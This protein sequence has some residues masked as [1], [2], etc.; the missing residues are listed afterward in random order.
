M[1][2]K[3][4]PLKS[5]FKYA[6][7]S[8]SKLKSFDECPYKF[9]QHY[10]LKIRPQEEPKPFFEKGGFIHWIL[11]HFPNL[12]NKK[13][14]FKLASKEMQDEWM[15]L[16][17]EIVKNPRV[18]QIINEKVKSEM[19]FSLNGEMRP[20]KFK[21]ETSLL[22]GYVDNI[23]KSDVFKI[24]DWKT[25]KSRV[26]ED[27]IQL[28]LYAMWFLLGAKDVDKVECTYAFVEQEDWVTKTYTQSDVPELRKLFINKINTIE[29]CEEFVKKPTRNCKWCDHFSNCRP[30]SF[31][32]GEK[33]G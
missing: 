17:K 27:D 1:N 16:A 33:N 24:I 2:K 21:K 12:P 7:Y 23:S 30:F 6:P 5:K 11:E 13:F 10:I 18:R 25:G 14:A 4:L 8:A 31:N 15:V 22:M 20:V 32:I 29:T 26:S 3:E 19:K 9:H 28:K